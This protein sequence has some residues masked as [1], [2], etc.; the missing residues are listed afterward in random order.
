MTAAQRKQK[1]LAELAQSEA[2]R[3]P[4]WR[5]HSENLAGNLHDAAKYI[6]EYHPEWDVVAMDY[7]NHNCVVVW[8]ERI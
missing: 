1:V 8:R 5:Y 4:R 7:S 2:Q 3:G 6:S